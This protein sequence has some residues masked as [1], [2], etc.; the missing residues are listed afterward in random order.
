MSF[1][2]VDLLLWKDTVSLQ[3]VLLAR[4]VL[5]LVTNPSHITNML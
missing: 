4:L 1:V 3:Y 5:A 2:D